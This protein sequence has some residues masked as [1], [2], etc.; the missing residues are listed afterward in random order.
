[1]LHNCHAAPP[2]PKNLYSC[3]LSIT[4]VRYGPSLIAKCGKVFLGSKLWAIRP[5]QTLNF[6]QIVK[7]PPQSGLIRR[8]RWW[9]SVQ[10]CPALAV[11][12]KGNRLGPSPWIVELFEHAMACGASESLPLLTPKPW[13]YVARLA[14]TAPAAPKKSRAQV[15][16]RQRLQG[17]SCAFAQLFSDRLF[18]RWA[19]PRPT[20][21]N[22]REIETEF[23]RGETAVSRADW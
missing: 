6:K 10:A 7:F 1:M 3:F 8:P 22:A 23:S 9:Q 19:R 13:L 17:L 2:K 18:E 20:K 5:P 21:P 11:A 15:Y 16:P 12:R 4:Y 14:E